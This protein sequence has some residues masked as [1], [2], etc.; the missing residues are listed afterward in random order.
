MTA[1]YSAGASSTSH[2]DTWKTLSW[3][4]INAHVFRLQVRIAKAEREGRTGRVKALQ[5]L[6]TSSFYAKCLA[7]KRV[8]SNNGSKTAG[9]DGVVLRTSHQKMKTVY[10]LKRRGY[11][12]SP[13]KRIY[14]PKK[15]GSLKM[16][17][18]SI[19][20]QRD[21]SMQALWQAAIAPIAEERAD[22]N[23]YGFRPKRSCQD[24]IEQCFKALGKG[25][26]ATWI[27]E[28]D[29]KSCFD[30]VDQEWLLRNIPMDKTILKKFLK[31]GFI[32]KGEI[33]P[34]N[35]GLPQGGV[36]SATLTVMALAGLERKLR[37]DK[38]RQRNKEKIN[39]IAYADDFIVTAASEQLLRDKIIPQLTK[40]LAEVG[41]ELSP[42]K[43]RV[44]TIDQGFD[45]LGFNVRKYNQGKLLIK[46]AKANVTR[47]LQEIKS[48]I[49][50]G[51]A[52][53]TE[54]L[55]HQLNQKI[56]GWTNYYRCVVSS[57]VFAYIDSEI[58]L[59]LTRWC[60]KRHPR[61]GKWWVMR[62]YYTSVGHNHWRF[63]C[64]VKDEEGKTTL[65]F[66]KQACAV[67][68]RRHKKILATANPFNP[69][70]K[71]YFKQREEERK[72]SRYPTK[73]ATSTGLRLVQPYVGLSG[74]Q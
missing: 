58:F 6:L 51:S 28:G 64:I 54:R 2:Q 39:M 27:L 68:I 14:I 43:T 32:E 12:T 24:A 33:H 36:I 35:L 73:N 19:P 52:L 23:A 37:S 11:Q 69:C 30:R 53:P 45:F 66:L 56:T 59:A 29:I 26:S 65:L 67:T 18:L 40:A 8:T 55:I 47:L 5:R 70:F 71:E 41:L 10:N 21:R 17:P 61:K 22:P 60:L 72:A 74:V 50:Q 38:E 15:P 9:V 34:T 46:P 42:E 3:S 62:K 4:K 48:I 7:V 57:S 1:G 44:T 31:A 20:T 49:K 25:F 63:H 13:L 16:R